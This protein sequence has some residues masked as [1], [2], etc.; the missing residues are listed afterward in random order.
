MTSTVSRVDHID[1]ITLSIMANRLDSITREMTNTMIRTARSTT[2]AAHDF[3]CSITSSEH[4]LVSA[5]GGFPVHVYGST[6]IAQ[7][8]ARKH[9]DFR[10]GDAFLHNDPYDGNTHAADHTLVVPVFFEGEHVFT[11][12]AKAHQVDIGNAQPT[13]YMPRARDV[14]EE[15]AL[16]FPCVKV[17]SDYKDVND[18]IGMARVRIRAFDTWYGDY[19]ASL[20][21]LRLAEKRLKAFCASFESIDHLRVFIRE[22]LNYGERMAT[23]GIAKLP[24][25][26]VE[27]QTHMDAFPGLPNGLDLRATVEIKPAEGRIIVDLRDNPDC[28]PTGLNL[29]EATSKNNAVTAILMALN[30]APDGSAFSVPNTS[31]SHRRI[32][33][34]VRENC[35]VGIPR[36]PA[37][38]SAATRTVTDRVTGMIL[39]GISS[40]SDSNIGAAEPPY[41]CPPHEAVVSGRDTRRNGEEFILQIFAGSS[42]GPATAFS[43]G[44]LS[45]ATI[46]G[47]GIPHLDSSEIVEQRYP[48]VVWQ[49][50]TVRTDSEGAGSYRGAP[51]TFSSYGPVSAPAA[52]YYY[53]EG[54]ENRPL[55]V[56]GGGTASGPEA[57]VIK[58]DG[59]AQQVNDVVA[60][61]TLATRDTIVSLGSGAGGYGSPLKREPRLVLEDVIDEYI[62]IERA[63]LAYGVVIT[64]DRAR[65]E[66][67]S[68]DKDGTEALRAKLAIES[69]DSE[70]DAGR[71][72][73]IA[74]AWYTSAQRNDASELGN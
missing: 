53:M 2:M 11:A 64:G 20:G 63:R 50:A 56:H 67:L 10:E 39:A 26:R 34:L 5:P 1:P 33:I 3:S 29:T 38:C 13:T 21:A 23:A 32:E 62:S 9:P 25:G 66:T 57:W 41:G 12:I 17:Q 31:G 28:T 51:G 43:D 44:W 45:F 58:A 15:G 30:T 4:D 74:P 59:S 19:L 49:H 8:M 72:P 55:G 60:E 16:I 70:H 69:T 24:E 68:I 6:L 48:L 14:Y 40:M 27:L 22:W 46:M 47:A 61:V 73:W 54:V 18:I 42:G 35:V 37:C 52:S 71:Q 36:H 65:W 7:S